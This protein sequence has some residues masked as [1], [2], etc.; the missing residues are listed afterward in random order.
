MWLSVALSQQSPCNLLTEDSKCN[1]LLG[2][3]TTQQH[4]DEEHQ[5]SLI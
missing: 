5:E 2:E 3:S 1:I 4:K